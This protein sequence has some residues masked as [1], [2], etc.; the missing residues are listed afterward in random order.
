MPSNEELRQDLSLA[1]E[2]GRLAS[3]IA[4]PVFQRGVVAK[5]KPDGS[6]VT[7]AD[8]EVERRL[9]EVLAQRRPGDAVLGEEG[10][11]RGASSRRWIIDPID[12]TS[13]FA[14]GQPTWGTHIALEQDGELV[15]GLITRPVRGEQW[16]ATRG[17]GAHQGALGSG[18]SREQLHVSAV[19][20]VQAA[21]VMCWGRDDALIGALL[22]ARDRWVKP[23]LDGLLELAA[24][25]VDALIDS[26]GHA[27]D[28]APAVVIV[29]EA[30][31]RFVDRQ[32]GHRHD[33]LGG[34]FTNG[35]LHAALGGPKSA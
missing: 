17:N 32:G 2:L 22:L 25:Q 6:P 14:R 13:H 5:K 16:W 29:E 28:V 1:F 35:P 19:T 18:V 10:G 4:L 3:E 12:G 33:L 23:T 34:W 26:G 21:R 7:E 30:G 20:E 27:W 24:G 11:A 31:G 8:V 9:V 15:L